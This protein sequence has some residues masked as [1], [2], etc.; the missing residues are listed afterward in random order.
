MGFRAGFAAFGGGFRS[1]LI[2]LGKVRHAHAS[3]VPKFS[4]PVAFGW[5]EAENGA[6]SERER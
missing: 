6:Q 5:K 1:F 4:R 3:S 2:G